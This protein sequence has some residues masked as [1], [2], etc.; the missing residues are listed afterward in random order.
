M[1]SV[2][3]RGRH[4]VIPAL[5]AA[6]LLLTS[7]PTSAGERRCPACVCDGQTGP[8]WHAA[9]SS[10]QCPQPIRLTQPPKKNGSAGSVWPQTLITMMKTQMKLCDVL[11]G[12][13]MA[14]LRRPISPALP[15]TALRQV[16]ASFRIRDALPFFQ[17][18]VFHIFM[19]FPLFFYSF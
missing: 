9:C 11:E 8:R 1:F 19:S 7:A 15:I 2:F 16:D 18:Y 13:A 6:R 14:L 4:S 12:P 17:A 5:P 10:P 3:V